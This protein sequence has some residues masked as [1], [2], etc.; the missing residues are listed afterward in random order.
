MGALVVWAELAGRSTHVWTLLLAACGAMTLLDPNVAWDI[1]F[2]LSALATAGLFAWA[3]PLQA[4]LARGPLA[5]RGLAWAVEPLTATL[6]ASVF[7]LPILLYHFGQLSLVA[8]IANVLMLP[9]VPWAM[10]WGALATTAG[11]LWLPLGQGMALGS[12]PFLQ[13][14][15]T[16]SHTLARLPGAATTFP[17]FHAAWVWGYYLVIGAWWLRPDRWLRSAMQRTTSPTVAGTRDEA[18][19][20]N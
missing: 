13:W 17:P 6:A 7:S 2:Q 16:A 10:L 8:P 4:Q 18:E 12:W 15:L 14:L 19:L 3:R 1:G 20:L 9:L 5:W 11:L